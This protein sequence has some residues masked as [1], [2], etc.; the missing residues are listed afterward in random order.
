[1]KDLICSEKLTNNLASLPEAVGNFSSLEEDQHDAMVD[2]LSDDV[3]I[4]D[5]QCS[6]DNCTHYL[7]T[8]ESTSSD[9]QPIATDFLDSSLYFTNKISN[10]IQKRSNLFG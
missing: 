8:H 1:M 10:K 5:D 9:Q 6:Q 2:C 4:D 7:A 3:Q